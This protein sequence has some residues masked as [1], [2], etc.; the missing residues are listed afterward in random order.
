MTTRLNAEN[1]TNWGEPAEKIFAELEPGDRVRLQVSGGTTQQQE[2]EDRSVVAEFL[3][4]N[5]KEHEDGSEEL[6]ASFN[7]PPNDEAQATTYTISTA[8]DSSWPIT[9]SVRK[10]IDHGPDHIQ[11]Q[12]R[13]VGKLT[14]IERTGECE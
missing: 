13:P 8:S 10:L 7:A 14:G 6:S 3:S 1:M 11:K 4:G 12:E 9:L 2:F 5:I